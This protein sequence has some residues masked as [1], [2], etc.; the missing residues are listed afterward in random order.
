MI[1]TRSYST[2]LAALGLPK[3]ALQK[4]VDI[5]RQAVEFFI[6]VMLLEWGTTFT[7][8]MNQQDFLTAAEKL[9]VPSK[10]RDT[11][12]HDFTEADPA[13]KR[14]PCYLRRAAI[15]AATGKVKAY[16][17][18]L[19][20]WEHTPHK[21]GANPPSQP[22]A[23]YCFPPLYRHKMFEGGEFTTY[24]QSQQATNSNTIPTAVVESF[25][26]AR[27]K[28]YDKNA[29]KWITVT[30]RRGDVK[31]ILRHCADLKDG[32]P[33]LI[34]K[35]KQWMM[36]FPFQQEVKLTTKPVN[37]QVVVGVDLGLNNACVCSA[38]T[39]DGTVLGRMFCKMSSEKAQLNQLLKRIRKSQRK[40]G[41]KNKKLWSRV[42]GLNRHISE[43]TARAIVAFASEFGADVIVMEH[44]KLQGKKRR[45]SKRQL[46]ALWRA[47]DVQQIVERLAHYR[48]MRVSKVCAW[49]TS[50]LAFDGS[51]FI[52]RDK[53]NYSMCT[54]PNPQ[55]KDKEKQ[56][57]DK[58][59]T[60]CDKTAKAPKATKADKDAKYEGGK[61]YNCDLSAS[62]NIAARYFVRGILKTLGSKIRQDIQA[63][64]PGC[65]H[66]STCCLNTL[67][68]LHA[69]LRA[70]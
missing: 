17:T 59:S 55:Y 35:G 63:K 23:G 18:N 15:N 52:R 38:M 8:T 44:L 60:G 7:S 14:M 58:G 6:T 26:H 42:K 40:G 27:I 68:K 20:K 37:D 30:L 33:T 54:F 56:S 57:A 67:I 51:G 61:R 65:T 3:K 46:L 25:C 24:S 19:T 11:V 31:Y 12:V 70:L 13:F 29:W 49:N 32:V 28:V 62:Y 50:R 5:Y 22:K 36:T 45:G 66:G 64:V 4:T 48:G 69:E 2:L 43:E 47:R 16:Q 53:D 39:S 21:K 34:N 1:F 41:R 10:K 9:C